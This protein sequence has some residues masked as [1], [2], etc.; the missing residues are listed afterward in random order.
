MKKSKVFSAVLAGIVSI[1]AIMPVHADTQEQIQM[2]EAQQ[3]EAENSLYAAQERISG[4]QG[5]M[6][7][8]EAYL[9]ELNA[10]YEELTANVEEM[11]LKAGEKEE[12]LKQV[13][14]QLQRA[15]I[16]HLEQYESMKLRL[17]YI[18]EHGETS[19]LET[20]LSAKNLADFLDRAEYVIK[21]SEYD[22]NMLEEYE[23]TQKQIA[24]KEEQIQEEIEEINKIREEGSQRRQELRDMAASASES[25][26]SYAQQITSDKEQAQML[27]Q[28]ISTSQQGIDALVAMAAQEMTAQETVVQEMNEDSQ[29]ADVQEMVSNGQA[30]TQEDEVVD[31]SFEYPAG[32]NP[33]EDTMDSSSMAVST[34][35]TVEI[36]DDSVGETY[37]DDYIQESYEQEQYVEQGDTF[38]EEYIEEDYTSQEE[39]T[40]EDYTSQEE[41]IEE[42]YTS[43][44]EY[45]GEDYTQYEESQIPEDT[46][47]SDSSQGTYLGTFT[48]T[49]YCG[50]AQCCGAAG[51]PT[52]SGVMP[53]AGHTVAM[54][55][56]PFGTQLLINGTVYTVEDLGTPY[57]HV[58]IYFDSHAAAL[59]FG[60]QSAEVYQLN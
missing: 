14:I 45:T 44:E 60:L 24:Q 43:Q 8:M 23:E 13:K 34:D 42:D 40:G 51:Q 39:Y 33:E 56:V 37:T 38:Q 25:I 26:S 48:L 15:K 55:G 54:A 3:Q 50:C 22:R 9:S 19:W 17:S 31:T 59:A 5:Q 18:Y 10:E 49:A 47:A 28:Q 41:Y 29:G 58:D 4:L 57:G 52:A 32:Y 21:I 35:V 53:V 1:T 30:G 36:E 20:L 16:D 2:M 46:G 11:A 6:Q 12:E 27:M 7:D